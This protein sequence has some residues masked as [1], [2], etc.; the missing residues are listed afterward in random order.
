M[1]PELHEISCL[2]VSEAAVLV[3]HTP[4]NRSFIHSNVTI[5]YTQTHNLIA[6][7]MAH[8]NVEVEVI[9]DSFRSCD[10]HGLE[11]FPEDCS[12]CGSPSHNSFNN[13]HIFVQL[14]F[15]VNV[16]Q[17][18]N[19]IIRRRKSF[20]QLH[21]FVCC[22]VLVSES[23]WFDAVILKVSRCAHSMHPLATMLNTILMVNLNVVGIKNC[24]TNDQQKYHQELK[25]CDPF[26]IGHD[27][28]LLIIVKV[29]SYTFE[30][31]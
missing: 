8:V 31:L 11:L 30:T 23:S 3:E 18:H 27:S 2:L 29:S 17:L 14:F 7:I 22:C 19:Q 21:C 20:S 26:I 12:D 25:A 5:E 9:G 24:H 13:V 16:L 4:L 1:Q 6:K 28:S 15:I 10:L